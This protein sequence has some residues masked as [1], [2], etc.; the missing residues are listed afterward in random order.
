MLLGKSKYQPVTFY[1]T[2]D[3]RAWVTTVPFDLVVDYIPQVL[4]DADAR[5]QSLAAQKPQ[6]VQGFQEVAGESEGI[7]LAVGRAR[8]A[9]RRDVSVLILGESGTG[10]ELF[11]RALHD[12]S[13][14]RD[15]A[16]VA[17]NCAAISRELLES[18]LFGHKKEL[19]PGPTEDRDGA[20]VAADGGTLFPSD[21]IGECEPFDA[22]QAPPP[23]PCGCCNRPM[24]AHA[25]G[26]S[27]ESAIPD[28]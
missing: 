11:A 18:E 19:S 2:Y 23:P 25:V 4:R 27:R 24:A 16:F 6:D 22:S 3:G 21:E 28:R 1:Q 12:A 7:R 26:Y 20:F 13:P 5:F 9:A 17:I 15:G 8:R 14:R 10:K